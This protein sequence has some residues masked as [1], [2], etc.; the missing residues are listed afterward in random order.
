MFRG[1]SQSKRMIDLHR[2]YTSCLE[3]GKISRDIFHESDSERTPSCSFGFWLLVFLPGPHRDSD[4]VF[5]HSVPSM[6]SFIVPAH[7]EELLIGATLAS[8]CAGA[9]A[10]GG[11]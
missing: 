4:F 9:R 2:H 6:I 1:Y 7:N 5:R 3:D 8:I 11:L 10:G